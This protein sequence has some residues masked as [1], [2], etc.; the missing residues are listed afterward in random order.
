MFQKIQKVSKSLDRNW[1]I[2]QSPSIALN[3]EELK[4]EPPVLN[5]LAVVTAPQLLNDFVPNVPIAGQCSR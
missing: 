3:C 1:T 4:V 5:L 2:A